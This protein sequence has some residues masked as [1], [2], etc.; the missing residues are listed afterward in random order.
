MKNIIPIFCLTFPILTFSQK[1]D[2]D[3]IKRLPEKNIQEIEIKTRK[4]I[5]EKKIDRLVFN[6][7][8]STSS[9]GADAIDILRIAPNVRV[10]NDQ[11]SII[12]KSNMTVMIDDRLIQLSGDDLINYL[13][14]IKSDNIKNI[15]VI[16]NPPAKYDAEGNS[17]IININ[18]K[19]AKS[20]SWSNSVRSTL[21]QATYSSFSVGNNFSYQKNKLS[22]L[23][24]IDYRRNQDIYSNDTDFYYPS[25]FWKSS[26]YEKSTTNGIGG[27]VN[28][29]YKFNDNTQLGIQYF[30]YATKSDKSNNN[31]SDISDYSNIL[32]D[33]LLSYGNTHRVNSSNSLN[34]NFIKKANNS[35]NKITFDLDYFDLKNDRENNFITNKTVS[36]NVTSEYTENISK[37]NIQNIS[38]RIDF[39]MPNDLV[40]INWGAKV[41]FTETKNNLSLTSYDTSEGLSSVN[42][43]QNNIF[44]YKEN[45]QALYVSLNK[46]INKWNFKAGLR[47]ESTQNKGYSAEL[48]QTNKNN[49]IKLFPT[50]YVLYKS[51]DKNTFSFSY[52]KRIRRPNFSNLN[53][54]KWYFN[55]NSYEEGNPFLQPSYSDNVELSHTYN[56]FLTSSVS[57]TKTN[58]GFG[59]ITLHSSDDLQNLDTQIIVRRNYFNSSSLNFS[60]EINFDIFKWWN[61]SSALSLFYSETNTNSDVLA[62]K[63]SGWGGDFSSTNS[64]ILNKSKSISLQVIYNYTYPSIQQENKISDFSNLSIGIKAQ[65][66]KRSIQAS[67]FANNILRSDVM[68]INSTS[69]N[70]YQQF[71]QYYD[72]QYV[73]LSLSYNFGNNKINLNKRNTSNE[74]EK[75]RSN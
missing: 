31:I 29:G 54:A 57:F 27:T 62:P 56:S 46:K 43:S 60:E 32:N 18:L 24:D 40:N 28:L 34:L 68:T 59:Q 37:Q 41:S 6:V 52:G 48:D 23:V 1:K 12:G 8:N 49:F 70:V 13:K 63:F 53:P 10:N 35:K 50:L 26:I 7:E 45:I 21:K 73:R 51:N 19:K 42:L 17:G 3:S 20:N 39:E 69:G 65:F 33:K 58:N 44:N 64:F 15:E 4:K 14:T 2:N 9:S 22:V 5:I 74:D 55:S 38:S 47:A 67:L 25:T 72:T 16:T 11:I 30:G 36:S 61:T 75:K 71:K 66:L